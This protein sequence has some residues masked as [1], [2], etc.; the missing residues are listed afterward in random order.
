MLQI[1]RAQMLESNIPGKYRV[2][3][4]IPTVT[5]FK[6]TVDL[7]QQCLLIASKQFR[8]I[9]MPTKREKIIR[10]VVVGTALK[11]F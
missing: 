9:K 5:I 6:S 4:L 10:S 3:S 8:C 1:W 7:K 11:L 2:K